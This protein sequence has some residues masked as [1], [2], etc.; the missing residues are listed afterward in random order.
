MKAKEKHDKFRE[1]HGN[2]PTLKDLREFYEIEE[3]K[4]IKVVRTMSATVN[5]QLK[6]ED[7]LDVFKN[8]IFKRELEYSPT[9]KEEIT[10]EIIEN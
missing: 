9:Y 5:F 10:Y 7:D 4:K 2:S 3:L 1:I 8:T 6:D